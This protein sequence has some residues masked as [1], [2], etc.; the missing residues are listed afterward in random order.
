MIDH[1][2]LTNKESTACIEEL[3][4]ANKRL[5]AAHENVENEYNTL[6]EE[7]DREEKALNTRLGEINKQMDSA[8]EKYGNIHASDEDILEI[9][10][11][12]RMFIVKRSTLTMHTMGTKFWALFNGRWENKLQRDMNGRIFLDVNPECFQAIV[13]YL[14]E[15][16][17]S[18]EDNAP[19]QPS[20]DDEH[21]LLLWQHLALFDFWGKVVA[22]APQSQVVT[23]DD[24]R[25]N[26]HS[27]LKEHRII[28]EL[29]LLHSGPSGRFPGATFRSKCAGKACVVFLI[30]VEHKC[31]YCNRDLTR[32]RR[33]TTTTHVGLYIEN[34]SASFVDCLGGLYDTAIKF[35]EGSKSK[36]LE[37]VETD[38]EG[39]DH[40][41]YTYLITKWEA[42]EVI[43]PISSSIFST[44]TEE[45]AQ[46]ALTNRFSE[47][48]NKAINEK[49]ACLP[50]TELKIR[51]LEDSFRDEQM[52]IDNFATGDAMHV[53]ALNVSGT[54][55]VTRRSTLRAIED[56]VLAQQFDDSK[57]NEQGYSS[58]RV[59][60]WSSD[61][62]CA[63]AK[64]IE[65]I[66]EDVGSVFKRNNITG[67][68]LLA[69]NMD[70]LRMLGIERA[71]T[72]CLLKKEIETLE[73]ASQAVTLID[74]CP[75]CFGKILDYLRMKQ[76]HS[77]GLAGEPSL[78]EVVEAQKKRFE[79][80][81]K[82]YFPGDA[83]KHFL[84]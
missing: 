19:D 46:R 14:N 45:P 69:L 4:R 74:H 31:S 20:V 58:V 1:P 36:Q 48:D 11:G 5:K 78:P 27:W 57:W 13:A 6:M 28:G 12:G 10:A 56:S 51:S 39:I 49:Q 55:M 75:Y 22:S 7:L 34:E 83:A 67:C 72:L 17:I 52:F 73:K 66:Q 40:E 79:K 70:G 9:N 8:A 81:V 80:V 2:H 35:S 76:A 82:F 43:G 30:E 41:V 68:E 62:V 42:F 23:T 71:G 59:K 25:S 63:W 64:N 47:D 38:Y 44:T 84:G 21:K 53:I 18:C 77:L 60:K 3:V 54:P 15:M 24:A 65:G 29:R 61:E 26:L 50:Q 33:T 32:C 37:C 16:M